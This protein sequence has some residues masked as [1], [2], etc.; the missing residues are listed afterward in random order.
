MRSFNANINMH[1]T[2]VNNT[3]GDEYEALKK[4]YA[5]GIS[6]SRKCLNCGKTSYI[7][8]SCLKFKK[9][10]KKGKKKTNY[11]HDS[12]FSS[13]FSFSDS[14]DL[15]SSHTCY[16]LKKKSSVNKYS[17]KKVKDKKNHIL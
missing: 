5:T 6:K 7:K 3:F 15:D 11:V 2:R 14:S 1:I 13:E 16:R 12:S 17:S 8:R 10:K 9:G 4:S